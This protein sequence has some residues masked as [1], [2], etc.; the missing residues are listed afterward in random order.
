MFEVDH[1]LLVQ[2]AMPVCTRYGLALAGGYEPDLVALGRGVLDD[3]FQSAAIRAWAQ[4]WSTRLSMDIAEAEPW[5]DAADDVDVD[6][7]ADE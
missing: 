6:V 2:A 3:E 7:D 1:A 4:A 5:S